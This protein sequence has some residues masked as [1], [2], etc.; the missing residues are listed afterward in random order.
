MTDRVPVEELQDLV[1]DDYLRNQTDASSRR[2]KPYAFTQG[3]KRA[4]TYISEEQVQE[5]IA[6][7][8]F[9]IESETIEGVSESDASHIMDGERI[10]RRDISLAFDKVDD[11]VLPWGDVND[12]LGRKET[13]YDIPVRELVI[14]FESED[15]E[16]AW[17][18][19]LSS[20]IAVDDPH[21][22]WVESPFFAVLSSTN[23]GKQ[24]PRDNV[25]DEHEDFYYTPDSD[26]TPKNDGFPWL[27]ATLDL[28]AI[29]SYRAW[30]H[31]REAV[32]TSRGGAGETEWNARKV[33]RYLMN[34]FNPESRYAG[35]I[36]LGN[37][38]GEWRRTFSLNATST[39]VFAWEGD[40]EWVQ[41]DEE[42]DDS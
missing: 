12:L 29:W 25:R 30:R 18:D 33:E 11:G 39:K 9:D 19:T 28:E 32:L 17:K 4:M 26:H 3:L 2:Y 8:E 21:L 14:R 16:E 10:Y 37:L 23:P 27:I 5:L 38:V 6:T 35:S 1:T 36:Y 24:A 22:G 41:L 42:P 13:L 31:D 7:R 20:A 34:Y 15:F 40:E